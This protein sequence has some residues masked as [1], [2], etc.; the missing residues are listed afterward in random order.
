MIS[1]AWPGLVRGK[2]DSGVA[3]MNKLLGASIASHVK[4][5]RFIGGTAKF[6]EGK[7]GQ[8]LV[9]HT[10]PPP[11]QVIDYHPFE[12]YKPDLS[13]LS[14]SGWIPDG[15]GIMRPIAISTA[16]PTNL[17]TTINPKTDAW[18]IWAVRTGAVSL[19][20]LYSATVDNQV[21]LTGFEAS[22]PLSDFSMSY[23]VTSGCDSVAL[24]NQTGLPYEYDPGSDSLASKFG[25][26]V[27]PLILPASITP[28]PIG[29]PPLYGLALVVRIDTAANGSG[30]GLPPATLMGFVYNCLTQYNTAFPTP[31]DCMAIPI[32]AISALGYKY[33]ES[34]GDSKSFT[35]FQI[36]YG[37]I[38][39]RYGLFENQ[40]QESSGDLLY[41]ATLN[42]RGNWQ[43]D[44]I[45]DE[46][47]YPGDTIQ[48]QREMDFT[49]SGGITVTITDPEG[50]SGSKLYFTELYMMTTTGFTSDPSTD[51]NFVRISGVDFS[52]NDDQ[53]PNTT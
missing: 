2:N 39:S 13:G 7:D 46:I 51:D 10:P 41:N 33:Y 44:Q 30:S 23:E 45:A 29:T 18:R 52:S 31:A 25:L 4:D 34:G 40:N 50:G 6:I 38:L 12:I 22:V 53:T 48:Y 1:N 42:F 17:P 8:T 26:V 11:A 32:G 43:N 47:F 28:S 37:N 3:W 15:S 27:T 14:T 36:Q 24:G 49:A 19:R 9:L 35:P 5:V 16:T 20:N 21:F